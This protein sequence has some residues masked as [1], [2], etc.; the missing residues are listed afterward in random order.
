MRYVDVEPDEPVPAHAT[1]ISGVCEM[2]T[3][4]GVVFEGCV[5]LPDGQGVYRYRLGW[6]CIETADCRLR[7]KRREAEA[8]ERVRVSESRPPSTPGEDPLS[9]QQRPSGDS[10]RNRMQTLKGQY[11][12]GKSTDPHG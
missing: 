2:C 6:R 3:S 1:Q 4:E 8:A 12:G 9:S 5:E 11:P 7:R 10:R